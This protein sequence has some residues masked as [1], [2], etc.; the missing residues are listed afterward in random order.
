MGGSTS[1]VDPH[2]S[3]Q[4]LEGK[5]RVAPVCDALIYRSTAVKPALARWVDDVS[6]WDFE[7]IAPAH[8]AAAKG[9]P[10]DVRAAF[11][12]TLARETASSENGAVV[13]K[14]PYASD[15]VRLLDDIASVL[16]QLRV[17]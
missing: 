1:I 5:W 14:R 15:D 16:I 11:A 4:T 12:P 9:T 8:F 7:Y 3:F 13:A 17:I 6:R 2:A 10:D